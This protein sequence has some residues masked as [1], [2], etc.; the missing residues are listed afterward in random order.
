[1]S[2][3]LLFEDSLATVL[4]VHETL[5]DTRFEIVGEADSLFRAQQFLSQIISKE[6]EVDVLLLDA[7]L[8]KQNQPTEFRHTFPLDGS[9]PIKK[10]IFGKAKLVVPKEIVIPNVEHGLGGDAR[11]IR[12]IMNTCGIDIPVIGISGDPME[13]NHVEVSIDIGKSGIY[14]ELLPALETL[15]SKSE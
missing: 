15:T 13:I 11:M 12:K 5:R 1:M 14:T 9:E 7:N 4:G 10:N 6:L 2:S 8:S 3:V